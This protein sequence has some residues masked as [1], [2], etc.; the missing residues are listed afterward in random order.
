[1]AQS[2]EQ[3]VRSEDIV[4]RY[5]G[6]EFVIIL[7]EISEDL[8]LERGDAIRRNVNSLSMKFKG[9]SLRPIT[10][11]IGMAMFPN[12][13]RDAADLLRKADH[14]LYGAKHAGRDRIHVAREAAQS[15][16]AKDQLSAESLTSF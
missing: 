15:Q 14:A 11:S 10:I 4:C 6:E 5:G 1:V 2:F 12:P 13:A 7:P 8:A 3:S 9:E 16:K